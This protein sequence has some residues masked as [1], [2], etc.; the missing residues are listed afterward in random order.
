MKVEQ[1]T[2]VMTLNNQKTDYHS[3]NAG[4]PIVKEKKKENIQSVSGVNLTG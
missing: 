1:N 4:T 3:E 2:D